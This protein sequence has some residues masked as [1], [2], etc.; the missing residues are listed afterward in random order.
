MFAPQADGST[1][2]A[3][4]RQVERVTGRW[5]DDI[6]EPPDIP[7]E[8]EHLW[9]WYWQLRTAQPSAGFGPAPLSFGEMD[10]WGRVTGN[11]L[12][13]WQVDVLLAMDAAFLEAQAKA[14]GKA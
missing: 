8:L 4:A 11:R 5:P 7:P 10:A 13:P 9:V 12:Q 3:I 1:L 14:A 6:P 2:A